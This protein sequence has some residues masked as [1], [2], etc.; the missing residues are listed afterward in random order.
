MLEGTVSLAS[1]CQLPALVTGWVMRGKH[2][3][4]AWMLRQILQAPQL[5]AVS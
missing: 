2:V 3:A 5:S 4:S 1:L